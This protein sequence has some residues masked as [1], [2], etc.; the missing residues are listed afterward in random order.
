MG[1]TR[2]GR[3][4]GPLESINSF[5]G[6]RTRGDGKEEGRSAEKEKLVAKEVGRG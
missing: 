5:R 2:T 4:D 3:R 6:G 1:G